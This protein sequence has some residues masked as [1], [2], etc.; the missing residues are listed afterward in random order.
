MKPTPTPLHVRVEQRGAE[1]EVVLDR[2]PL[3]VLDLGT[4]GT[5]HASLSALRERDDVRVVVLRS[6][7][8]GTFSAGADV[9]DHARDRAPSMLAAMHAVVRALRSLPMPTIA[10]VDGRCL[11]GGCELALACDLVVA[12]PRATFGQPEIDLGCFPPVA[13]AVLPRLAGRQA[14]ELVLLGR[15][16]D[17][18][19]A[20][21]MGLVN[22][23]A[24]DAG[25]EVR[26][27]ADALAAKSRTAL[28]AAVRA[29]RAGLDGTLD[30]ALDRNERLYLDAV[31]PTA[32]A[33][34]GVRA[35]LEKRP[36]VWSGR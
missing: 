4:L 9:A 17:A 25:A 1:V 15:A 16:V 24:A 34:E 33:D 31:V 5:L 20:L 11:G 32:D 2:P 35:F 21:A 22:R 36:P 13:A 14:S 28:A 3:N 10:L 23:V 18:A 26:D 29:L 7:L 27:L 6:A 30:E 19:E 12:S 8:D